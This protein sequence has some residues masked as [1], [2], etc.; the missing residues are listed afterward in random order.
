MM[1]WR[2]RQ[3]QKHEQNHR[4][5]GGSGSGY[6]RASHETPDKMEEIQLLTEVNNVCYLCS[7]HM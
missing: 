5:G 1:Y 7:Y 3:Q 4:R 6:G 2:K